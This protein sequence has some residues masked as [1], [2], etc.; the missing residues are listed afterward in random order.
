MEQQQLDA[1]RDELMRRKQE[2]ENFDE[3]N[4]EAMRPVELDQTTV[5]RLSRMD[6]MQA[7]QMAQ[8][9]ARRRVMQRQRIDGALRRIES[10]DYGYC[11]VCG[12][13]IDARRLEFDP[14]LT[15]CVACTESE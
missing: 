13:E 8:E 4:N 12:E 7:Q 11:F 5:G 9:Q 2:L 6:A 1:L 15:R 10:G 14:A 3:M